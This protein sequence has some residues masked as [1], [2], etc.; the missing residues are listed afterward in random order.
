M[1]ERT[2]LASGNERPF[3]SFHS[4]FQS[5][6]H[7]FCPNRWFRPC[8]MGADFS[9]LCSRCTAL[10]GVMFHRFGH[11][12]STFLPRLGSTPVTALQRYYAG[13]DCPPGLG[14]RRAL[15]SSRTLTSFRAVPNHPMSPC[16]GSHYSASARQASHAS[17]AWANRPS[18]T[19]VWISPLASR[20]ITASNRIGFVCLRPGSSFP[21]ALHPFLRMRS[22]SSV[23]SA[24]CLRQGLAPCYKRALEGAHPCGLVP[25]VN[26]VRWLQRP[27]FSP[28]FSAR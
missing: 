8:P 12:V 15:P 17:T 26:Q 1:P 24:E 11:R 21:V 16:R 28:P 7:T 9:L 18:S 6:Q 20:L 2:H 25:Q 14:P 19:W 23:R 13:S 5:D 27:R 4:G 22:Y 3:A 10:P